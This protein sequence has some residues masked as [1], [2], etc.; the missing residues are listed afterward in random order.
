MWIIAVAMLEMP[1]LSLTRL[2]RKR[3]GAEPA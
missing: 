1:V 3:E 2:P